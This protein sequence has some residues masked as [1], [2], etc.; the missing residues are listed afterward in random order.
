MSSH[1]CTS[2][3]VPISLSKFQSSTPRA[4]WFSTLWSSPVSTVKITQ[5]SKILMVTARCR[6]SMASNPSGLAMHQ[7]WLM[8]Q[9]TYM[10]WVGEVR[11]IKIG[12]KLLT[13]NFIRFSW[14]T[15]LLWTWRFWTSGTCLTMTPMW[16]TSTP[17]FIITES[18]RTSLS[19]IWMLLSKKAIILPSSTPELALRSFWNSNQFWQLR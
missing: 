5:T 7:R 14:D 3:M 11:K 19:S 16:S 12:L 8:W 17:S 18:S 9:T 1:S 2:E 15:V 10:S 13:S 6:D 4:T